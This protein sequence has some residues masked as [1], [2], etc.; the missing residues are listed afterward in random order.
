MLPKPLQMTVLLIVILSPEFSPGI[1]A[2]ETETGSFSDLEE[3]VVFS[4]RIEGGSGPSAEVGRDQLEMSDQIDMQDIFD[5]IDGLSTLGGDDEGNAI[6]IGGLSPDLVKVT[7]DGQS[8]SEGR[9]N[10]GFVAGDMPADMILRVDVYKTPTAA[11]EEGGAGGRVNLRMRVPVDIPRPSTSINARLGYVPDDGDF[12]PSGSFFMARPAESRKF[13]YM[14]SV[15][16]SDRGKQTDNQRI[17]NWALRDF[18]GRSAYIPGQVGSNATETDQRSIFTGLVLGFRPQPSLDISGKILLSQKPKDTESHS[19]QHRL[20]R[21]RD[22]FPLAFDERIVS[23]LD[24]SDDRRR[25]LRVIG[26]TREDDTDS[27]IL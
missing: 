1:K 12:S 13:G 7:L 21:Q 18:D 15:S 25:N 24:S 26:S 8:F 14:L 5:D 9:G 16:L 11:M 10:G 27:V 20:E 22:I 19:L 3:V 2:Q 4:D 23:E 6:S 17:S